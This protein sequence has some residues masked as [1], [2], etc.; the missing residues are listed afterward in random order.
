MSRQPE[1]LGT[2]PKELKT[3]TLQFRLSVRERQEIREGAE[4][5]G[6][7][8]S[9]FVLMA[10]NWMRGRLEKDG[11]LSETTKPSK[12]RLPE[13]RIPEQGEG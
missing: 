13:K 1:C 6:V 4:A 8:D 9:Q 2:E 10:A 7:A 12:I 5:L 3:E 11:V